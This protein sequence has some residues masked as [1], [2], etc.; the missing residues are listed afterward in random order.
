[1][2]KGKFDPHT[3]WMKLLRQNDPFTLFMAVPTVY[4]LLTR[5]LLEGKLDQDFTSQQIREILS[6]Y[7]LMVSGSAALPE[8]QM[9]QWEEISGQHLLE[10][11]GMTEIL[12]ALSNPYKPISGRIAGRV[13]TELPGVEAAALD[14]ET[15]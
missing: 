3:V 8:P 1:M 14:L 15:G 13:G 6:G 7:R 4:A 2:V 11:F 9:K 12:M 5:H 10:R